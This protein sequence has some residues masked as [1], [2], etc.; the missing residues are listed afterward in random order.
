MLPR[1]AKAQLS[2]LGP[3]FKIDSLKQL[4]SNNKED[5]NKVKNLILLSR[6]YSKENSDSSYEIAESAL[7]LSNKLKWFKG[8]GG[9]N[10]AKGWSLYI[11]GNYNKAMACNFIAQR[12]GETYH[13][14][15]LVLYALSNLGQIYYSLG[16]LQKAINFNS[17]ALK[18]AQEIC[19]EWNIARNVG[20]LGTEYLAL[21]KYNRAIDHF[22]EAYQMTEK[23]RN[24]N[25]SAVWLSNIGGLYF[26]MKEYDS[27]LLYLTKANKLFDSIGNK[28]SSS[29]T[30]LDIGKVYALKKNFKM[31]HKYLLQALQLS[32]LVKAAECQKESYLEL[33]NLYQ[34]AD[35]NLPGL[36]SIEPKNDLQRQII[37]L[38]CFKNYIN[39]KDSIDNIEV[40]KKSLALEYDQRMVSSKMEARKNEIIAMQQLQ[41]QKIIRNAFIT[42]SLLLLLLIAI[43]I[44]RNS[45]KR[46]IELDKMRN[47]IS[48]D[49]HDDI[50]STLSSINILSRTAQKQV[51]LIGD[52]KTITSLE[53]I[54]ERSQRLLTNMGDI[55]WNI[56]PGNDALEEVLSRMREYATSMLEARDIDYGFGSLK[57]I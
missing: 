26:E 30:I 12:I 27:A 36:E 11:Q 17:K 18:I 15:Q 56:H 33:S 41:T 53:K 57:K 25:G 37:A 21:K 5:T 32:S 4:I 13:E 22:L 16:D 43:I 28:W 38:T 20:M 19:D 49:L 50:G 42:G 46:K 9:A 55:I 10:I 35:V 7:I 44:N 34:K 31:S 8:I 14:P 1:I 52:E 24:T 6:E 29:E 23:I 2:S 54:H 45:L 39:L 48:R 47:R 40:H 3:H 51:Q